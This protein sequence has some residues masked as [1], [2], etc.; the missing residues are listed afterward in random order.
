MPVEQILTDSR[1]L[2]FPATSLFFAIGGPRRKGGAFIEE[3]FAKGVRNFVVDES[4]LNG[5]STSFPQANILQVKNVLHA[6][7]QLTEHHRKQFQL[8]VVGITGSNGK[9]I[10]KEWLAQLL[11]DDFVVAK[12][13]KSYNSQLGV[14][15]SVHQLN[16]NYSIVRSPKSYN[17]QIG[18]PLSVWQINQHHTLGIFEAG[19][20]QPN[21]MHC[22]LIG[23]LRRNGVQIP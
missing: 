3:L 17:S 6:L 1:K 2:L 12:S 10:V 5:D 18:V 23:R 7:Q 22:H 19:I 20:S 11:A 4:F 21:E 9:T 15:L 14:P 13:P 8:P 16:E